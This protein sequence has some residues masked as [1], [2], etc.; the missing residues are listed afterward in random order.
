M[1]ILWFAIVSVMMAVYVVLDGFDFGAG[2]YE[3]QESFIRV[4]Q[5]LASYP[6]VF[7]V[8]PSRDLNE[9]LQ[10]LRERDTQPPADLNFDFNRHFLKHHTYYD[11]AKFTVYTAGKTPEETCEEILRLRV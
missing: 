1:E 9:S 4:K 6:N 5:A 11:L 7:L 2:I 8:L 3:S 10:I